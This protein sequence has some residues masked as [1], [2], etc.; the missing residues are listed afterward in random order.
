MFKNLFLL[1]ISGVSSIFAN[2]S[3][4]HLIFDPGKELNPERIVYYG[5]LKNKSIK[6]DKMI[7]G[8][9]VN[10][11]K[12]IGEFNAGDSTCYYYT[13]A[14]ITEWSRNVLEYLFKSVGIKFNSQKPELT[15]QPTLLDFFILEGQMYKGIVRL[16]LDI[17]DTAGTIITTDT[18]TGKS[19]YWGKSFSAGNY[20]NSIGNAWINVLDDL[21]STPASP[22]DSGTIVGTMVNLNDYTP[23][24]KPT[25]ITGTSFALA[26]GGTIYTIV[27]LALK[28][29]LY[30]LGLGMMGASGIC[31]TISKMKWDKYNR[32]KASFGPINE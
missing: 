10:N 29:E 23:I 32:F 16:K 5:V 3:Y 13:N 22:Q 27:A 8:R 31:F 21:F 12:L 11:H 26:I 18:A 7:D 2:S 20:N 30:P 19:N 25:G 6:I 4:V 28:S 24:T 14:P 1:I 17:F 9:S 15:I